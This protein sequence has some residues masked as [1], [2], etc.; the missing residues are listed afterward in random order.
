MSVFVSVFVFVF[1]VVVVV[2]VG[3]GVDVVFVLSC[4]VLSC[5]VL[6]LDSYYLPLERSR[7]FSS[8]SVPLTVA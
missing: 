4:L 7:R 2:V 3:V 6:P 5:R 8:A 1:V